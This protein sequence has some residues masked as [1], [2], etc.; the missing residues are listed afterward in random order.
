M[1]FFSQLDISVKCC[2]TFLPFPFPF[3]S[4][5]HVKETEDNEAVVSTVIDLHRV[6]TTKHLPAV[7]G[8]VKVSTDKPHRDQACD[9]Q[10][11]V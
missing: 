9:G 2:F 4:G 11:P 7:Q 5:F 1:I 6:I 10:T 8:W 3:L